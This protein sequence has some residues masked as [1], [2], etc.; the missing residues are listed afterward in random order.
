MCKFNNRLF[1]IHVIW[2]NL[3]I[4]FT[5]SCN[6]GPIDF[7]LFDDYDEEGSSA[8]AGQD[9]DLSYDQR[10]N[11]TGNFRLNIDG[12][13]I[14]VPSAGMASEMVGTLAQNYIL[15][16][17]KANEA[18]EDDDSN[19]VADEGGNDRPYEFETTSNGA[20]LAEQNEVKPVGAN[21]VASNYFSKPVAIIN[22]QQI[23]QI[24]PTT[25]HANNV[26]SESIGSDNTPSTAEPDYAAKNTYAH[27]RGANKKGKNTPR[28]RNK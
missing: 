13:V 6:C 19:D 21:S 9:Y 24:R 17:V 2:L 15:G 16:L 3:I 12:V 11:G 25:P 27:H 23:V 22:S 1:T 5:A 20:Q 8:A 4:L 7:L 14:G 28:R 26:N 18:S 10:Q